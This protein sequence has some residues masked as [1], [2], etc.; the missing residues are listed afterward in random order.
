[1]SSENDSIAVTDLP[2]P[3]T[4][5]MAAAVTSVARTFFATLWGTR[6]YD[7]KLRKAISRTLSLIGSAGMIAHLGSVR[8]SCISYVPRRSRDE[9]SEILDE[10][11][12]ALQREVLHGNARVT[13]PFV[14]NIES[15]YLVIAVILPEDLPG[16]VNTNEQ[17]RNQPLTELNYCAFL[18]VADYWDRF[19]Q[20][21]L[22]KDSCVQY[23]GRSTLPL[24]F[25]V[26]RRRG[27][28]FAPFPPLI[29]EMYWKESLLDLDQDNTEV[30][31]LRPPWD[32]PNSRSRAATLSFDLRKSTFCMDHADDARLFGVWL[33]ELVEILTRVSH[34]HGGVFDKFTGDGAL[35]HFLARECE[36]VYGKNAVD[37]ALYCAVDM[38][39]A[40]EI[41]LGRLQSTILR[42]NS[43][44]LGAGIA[45]DVSET[46]WSFD[47]RDNPIT[48][49]RGVVGACR[50]CDDAPAGRIRLTEIAYNSLSSDV[51]CK[52]PQPARV[53]ASTK[54]HDQ[55]MEMTVLELAYR[56]LLPSIRLGTSMDLVHDVCERIYRRSNVR[57]QLEGTALC[58]RSP[59]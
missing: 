28:R 37:A 17:L 49:G 7:V 57:Y 38:Q 52:T 9:E 48:V 51:R 32:M 41:H 3:T 53:N 42:L 40:I 18:Y 16:V 34:L 13:E 2:A 27:R 4:A 35:V 58:R 8:D 43:N 19:L 29:S 59:A 20:P 44:L 46:F 23:H 6:G 22:A 26:I 14:F 54:E 25:S 11:R 45:I 31:V 10:L 56:S 36:I 33:D 55:S 39:R 47:H 30:P 12:R 1:M 21:E 15:G 24:V 50:I 5:A